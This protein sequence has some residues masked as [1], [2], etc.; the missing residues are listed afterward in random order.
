MIKKIFTALISTALIC[1]ILLQGLVINAANN[2]SFSMNDVQNV[3][4]GQEITIA[5]T[6]KSNSDV[7]LCGFDFK[8]KYNNAL[9]NYVSNSLRSDKFAGATCYNKDGAITCVWGSAENIT[10]QPGEIFVLNFKAV[11]TYNIPTDITLDFGDIYAISNNGGSLNFE[12]VYSATEGSAIATVSPNLQSDAAVTTVIEQINNL[13]EV[14]YTEEYK[15]KLDAA[16]NNYSK[17]SSSQKKKVINYQ[18]LVNKY[19]EYNDFANDNSSPEAVEFLKTH[20]KALELRTSTVTVDD[21]AIVT[22]AIKDWEQ[23]PVSAQLELTRERLL[24]KALDNAIYVLNAP[25]R[26]QAEKEALIAAAKEEIAL[27]KKNNAWQ[28]ELTVDKVLS[29][30]RTGLATTK[31]ELDTLELLNDLA[32]E[33]LKE[34]GT[35]TLVNALYNKANEL[36]AIENPEDI[37]FITEA[38]EFRSKFGYVLGLDPNE[39]TYDDVA[40]INMAYMV[41]NFLDGKTQGYLTKEIKVLEELLSKAEQLSPE[42]AEVITDTEIKTETVTEVVKETETV[43]KNITDTTAYDTIM[44]AHSRSKIIKILLILDIAMILLAA[45]AKIVFWYLKR[46]KEINEEDAGGVI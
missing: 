25:N 44:G 5:I 35:V 20:A 4:A 3:A 17:L 9:I 42:E 39:L 14:E 28:L 46:E 36:Y 19:N 24:L 7:K 45:A 40:D 31:S 27:F 34:D 26:E 1:L 6:L 16:L 41:Y 30:H 29:G 32:F 37:E 38:D 23:L 33:M 10:V 13:G 8:I 2:I 22:A 21:E 18:T 15:A 43:Y 11:D 12:T